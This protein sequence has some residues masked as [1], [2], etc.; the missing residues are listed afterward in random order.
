MFNFRP[1]IPVLL[2][3]SATY[4]QVVINE[5]QVVPPTSSLSAQFQ[6]MFNCPNPTFGAEWVELYNP[7]PCTP[8]DISGFILGS[9][10]AATNFGAIM[11]PA[12]TIIPPLGFYTAGGALSGAN[13]NLQTLCATSNI[14]VDGDARWF[15]ENG[16]GWIGLYN[17]SGASVD[18]VYWTFAAGEAGKISTDPEYVGA[19]CIPSGSAA[20]SLL[21]ANAIPGIEYAGGGPSMGTSLI[22][23]ADGGSTWGQDPTPTP[24]TCNSVCSSLT[25]PLPIVQK[26]FSGYVT[27]DIANLYWKV[28]SD[29]PVVHWEIQVA[30]DATTYSTI[31]EGWWNAGPHN[32]NTQT[33]IVSGTAF[34]RILVTDPDGRRNIAGS[35]L[36]L[37]TE[38]NSSDG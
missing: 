26:E 14:C 33:K 31:A 34:F 11:F 25:C 7:D 27:S 32:G 19:P 3:F 24:G 38:P 22:R 16:D 17:A 1:L 37:E 18:A 15:L 10:T 23:T 5:I 6:S 21:P 13:L 29:M 9:R 12:G 8:A 36:R 28:D 35:I 2:T 4:A 20:P 30:D